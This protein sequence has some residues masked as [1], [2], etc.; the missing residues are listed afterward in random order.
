MV[1]ATPLLAWPGRHAAGK[2]PAPLRMGDREI[3]AFIGWGGLE[4]WDPD[5][6]LL[7]LCA[8]YARAVSEFSCGQCAPCRDG[9]K[10]LASLVRELRAGRGGPAEVEGAKAIAATMAA[11]SRCELGRSSPGVVL[12]I[13]DRLERGDLPSRP[14]ANGFLYRSMVTAPCMQACPLHLDVPRYVEHIRNGRFHEALRTIEERLPFAGVVG[15][16]CVMPCEASCRRGAVDEPVR[17]RLLKRFAADAGRGRGPAGRA[18]PHAGASARVAVVGAGPAGLACARVLAAR[19]HEVTVFDRE[20]EAGGM[21]AT[22][23]PSYRLPLD[24]LAEEVQAIEDLGVRFVRGKELGRDLSL[25]DLRRQ[26]FRAVFLAVGTHRATLLRL[27]GDA[28][29]PGVWDCLDFLGRAKAGEPVAVGRRVVV[30]GGGN[31]AIDVARTARR[32]GAEEVRIV[33]RRRRRQ[34]RAHAWEVEEAVEEGI[35]VEECWAPRKIVVGDGALRGIEARRANPDAGGAEHEQDDG[36]RRFFEADTVVFAIGM[37][38]EDTLRQGA[39]GL[40]VLPDG[41]IRADPVTYRTSLEG[42]F[43]GGDCVTGPNI[44][45]QACAHGLQAGLQ[46]AHYLATGRVERLAEARDQELLRALEVHDAEERVPLP[47]GPGRAPV[48]QRVPAERTGDFGEV[49]Q[50][51]TREAAVA[52]AERCLRCYRVVTCAYRA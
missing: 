35:S 51:L 31:V 28:S 40:E 13:L 48:K 33:Y 10:V 38:V 39:E 17:I 11:T 42:V 32:L 14:R 6:D 24:V 30:L 43:A 36:E 41:R 18:A 34:M 25:A 15:R 2:L 52:E 26:G 12:S 29:A 23:I 45:V 44:A 49:E 46:I 9:S 47:A 27:E 4:V 22:A 1:R 37:A 3:A 5:V 7:E 20:R 50:G 8:V 19:G 16:V 21:M